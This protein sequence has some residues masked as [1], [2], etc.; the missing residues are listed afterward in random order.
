LNAGDVLDWGLRNGPRFSGALTDW[1]DW[2]ATHLR[3]AGVTDV[4]VYGDSHPY[5][6]GAMGVA[7]AMGLRVHVLEQGYLRPDWI[8]LERDGVNGSSTLPREPRHYLDRADLT[9][10]QEAVPVG[11]LTPPAV[12]RIVAY[13]AVA[14]LG[15]PFFPRY[16]MPYAQSVPLQTLGHIRRYLMQRTGKRRELA[17]LGEA[18]ETEAPVFLA[19]LQRPG[20]SQ[21]SRHS[22]LKTNEAFAAHVLESFAKAAAPRARLIFKV[23]PLDPGVQNYH[24]ALGRLAQAAGLDDR[25]WVIDGGRLGDILPKVAG[26]VVN[27]STGGLSAIEFV[28]PTIVLGRA[29]YDMPGLTHQAGLAQF[30]RSPEAPDPALYEAFRRVL[31]ATSQINGAYGTTF[32]VDLLL[33]VTVQRLLDS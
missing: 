25:V 23:H 20:D 8:T 31:L 13:H 18:L 1:P 16:R 29:I 3:S 24:R 15:W 2:L 10:P 9:T 14:Y 30:W 27:N 21:L 22:V 28:R 12:R 32:G 7:K 5:A 6:V 33:P 17:R 11:P 26:V 19:L 4:I